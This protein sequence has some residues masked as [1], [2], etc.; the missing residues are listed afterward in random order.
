ML[1]AGLKAVDL[2][3]NKPRLFLQ[4]SISI[5][6]I[7]KLNQTISITEVDNRKISSKF[8]FTRTCG[9]D[10]FNR[11]GLTE[12]FA[13]K[14]KLVKDRSVRECRGLTIG[15]LSSVKE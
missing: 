15:I 1:F 5:H 4:N 12:Y 8:P 6:G 7:S 9:I 11:K 13:Y 2:P 3:S 14:E 10:K